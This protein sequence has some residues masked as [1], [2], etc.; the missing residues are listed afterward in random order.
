VCPTRGTLASHEVVLLEVVEA[1]LRFESA[2]YDVVGPAPGK[3]VPGLLSPAC[4]GRT[5]EYWG[6]GDAATQVGLDA[7]GPNG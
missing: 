2:H 6:V 3:R 7:A 5:P 1:V 4:V